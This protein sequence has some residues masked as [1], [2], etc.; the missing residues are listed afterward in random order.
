MTAPIRCAILSSAHV[1]TAAYADALRQ[2]PNAALAAI[3]DDNADRGRAFAD[4]Y[5][6]PFLA[7]L[8]APAAW[9][10]F[11]AVVITSENS[12]HAA[13]CLEACRAGKHVLCEKPLATTN[14]DA[15]AMVAAADTAGVVLATAFPM[16]HSLPAIA[17]KR[18][19]SD[20]GIGEVLAVRSTNH[21]KMPPGWF[22]DPALAGGGAVMDHTVHVVDLLRWYLEDEP[23]EVY[24]EISNGFHH[25]AVDDAAFLTI[26]FRSGVVV[27]LDPS[28]SR[29]A[30]FPMWGD[31][32]LEIAGTKGTVGLDAFGQKV[33]RYPAENA[34]SEWL[35]YGADADLAL[36]TDFVAAV[37]ERRA[38]AATGRDGARALA[39]A[40]AAYASAKSGQPEVIVP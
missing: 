32:T 2:V 14:E 39:V 6:V 16:R 10:E 7:D 11:D 29:P 37:R 12:R 26:T 34:P 4:H 17:V 36:I 5:N 22:R 25:I 8:R 20:G 23:V 40:L 1:H 33:V 28:W 9:D 3:W 15:A 38:P 13:L 35:G 31:L 27:T 21:G 24:A 19:I 30:S 18:T